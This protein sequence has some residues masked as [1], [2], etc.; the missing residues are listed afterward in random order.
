MFTKNPVVFCFSQRAFDPQWLSLTFSKAIFLGNGLVAI[1]SG[2]FANLLA[3]NLGFGPVAPF[4]AAAC[5]LAI[6]M[7]I[8]LSSWTENYGD[9]SESKNLLAQFRGAAAAITS[10]EFHHHHL[11][12]AILCLW[13]YDQQ[14]V[15]FDGADEKIAL[16]GAIQSLF[17]GSMYTFVFLWTPALSPNEEDI[18]HGF[19][20]ATFMLSS[21]LG[22]SIASRLM[23]RSSL[24]V[25]SYL[26]AVFVVSAFTLFLPVLTSVSILP[27]ISID[28]AL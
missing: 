6:G 15:L 7:A 27:P 17:E 1:V 10:G 20:F 19:I 18:P 22:S 24:R 23:A 11:L 14:P 5:F 9:P 21:M 26:Q 4:D 25:E 13:Y 3:D 16:L 8:I 12:S 28:E 2:L